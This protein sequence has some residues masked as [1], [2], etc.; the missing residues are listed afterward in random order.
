MQHVT[1]FS[2]VLSSLLGAQ[3]LLLI[4]RMAIRRSKAYGF[5]CRGPIR[6]F[7]EL[8]FLCGGAFDTD[9]QFVTISTPLREAD[10][11]M[12]RAQRM[13]EEHSVYLKRVAGPGSINVQNALKRLLLLSESD[14]PFSLGTLEKELLVELKRI[15]PQKVVY[16]G[17]PA[18]RILIQQA[19]TASLQ[20]GFTT[21]R[22]LTLITAL[23]FAFGQGCIDDPLYPWIAST[24]QDQRITG[25]A[26]RAV[27]LEAKASTWLRHVLSNAGSGSN[28]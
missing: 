25:A 27:R 8:M 23:M 10:D 15:F 5:T 21:A 20:F 7:L 9:P 24:L 11:Q 26:G 4:V 18:L 3:Q 6:L 12:L 14:L 2:P 19:R 17:E 1:A 28:V 13:H 16:T 22:E